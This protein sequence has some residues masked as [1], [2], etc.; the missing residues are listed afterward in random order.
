VESKLVSRRD[1]DFLLF[2][3]LQVEALLAYP[4]FADHTRETLRSALDVSEK[5][6][7][8]RFYPINRALDMAEP[9]LTD[10]GVR[11]HPELAPALRAF[12]DAGLTRASADYERGGMQLPSVLANACHAFF[13]AASAGAVGYPLLALANANLLLAHGSPE[14]IETY[15]V[16]CLEGR[17]YG[18][19]CL[20]EPHAGSS[21]AD[22]TTRAMPRDDGSYRLFGSKMWI[23]A[24][25]H[26]IG[27]NIHHLVLAKVPLEG[28]ALAAGVQGLSL[29]IVPKYL[30]HAGGQLRNDVTTIG[31]NHKLGYRGTTNCALNF[32]DGTHLPHGQRGAIGFLV[33]Q[34]GQGLR[35]MFHM[36]SEARIGVG[37]N[38]T[39]LGYTAYLHSLDYARGRLQGRPPGQRPE[40]PPATII[41]HPDVR[42]MLLAQKCYSESALALVLYCSRLADVAQHA[43]GGQESREARLL[44]ELLTPVVKSWPSQWCLEGTQLAIQVHGGCGYT[45]DHLVEIVHAR[46]APQRDPR[47]N[48]RHPGPGPPDA[49][50]GAW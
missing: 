25:D 23:S 48:P 19:M 7:L 30:P 43:G 49:P 40:S 5:L 24:G 3:W 2:D 6:A 15:A 12:S 39:M 31:L 17:A 20:S 21:L 9:K 44:L 16:P 1:L 14:Q 11:T 34:P 35:C 26:D 45:R 32:G 47:G 42:R 37:L 4:R 38:A 41:S 46:P 36:M 50:P 27:E 18:T 22:I 10:G 13:H 33:G 29:F 28:G 8:E